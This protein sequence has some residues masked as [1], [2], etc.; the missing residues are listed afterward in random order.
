MSKDEDL[1]LVC[2][3]L[4]GKVFRWPKVAAARVVDDHV[5]MTGFGQSALECIVYRT[6][7]GQIESHS[8]QVRQLW[9]ARWIARAAPDFVSLFRGSLRDCLPNSSAD[10]G[11]ENLLHDLEMASRRTMHCVL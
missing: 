10:A 3:R 2:D 9:D 6:R 11:D 4:R 8:V 7:I 5:E 1:K